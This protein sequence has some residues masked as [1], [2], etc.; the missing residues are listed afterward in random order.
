MPVSGVRTA[1]SYQPF[2]AQS[3]QFWQQAVSSFHA[4]V[5]ASFGV[6]EALFSQN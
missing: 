4:D 2:P 3:M 1:L 5:E 6:D